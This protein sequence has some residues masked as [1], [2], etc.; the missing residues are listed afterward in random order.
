M[1][2]ELLRVREDLKRHVTTFNEGDN[3]IFD[4]L[5]ARYRKHTERWASSGDTAQILKHAV[6]VS[7]W[8]V[9]GTRTFGRER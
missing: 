7:A 8:I 3:V 4:R 6:H 1:D 2:A 9:F 5:V